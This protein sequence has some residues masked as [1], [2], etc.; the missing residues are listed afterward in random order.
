MKYRTVLL[1][2]A[3]GAGKGT[4]GKILGA[5]PGIFHFA[6]GDAFRNL[7][8][9][10]P[11]GRIFIDYSSRGELVPDEPTINLWRKNIQS[12]VVQGRFQPDQDTLVLDGIP[13]NPEQ[14]A[15]LR[16]TIDV[17]A[18]FNLTCSDMDKMV[19]RL[20]RRALREN[21][22]D[23]ANL[24]TIKRRLQTYERETRPVLDYYGPEFVH[25]IDS[26]QKPVAVLMDILKVICKL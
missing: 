24:E 5:V 11:L 9:D 13:R 21:R 15:M 6:C 17:K 23:D 14:A 10:D 2:G 20:Q 12:S 3:P 22:L 18:I 7:R 19:E 25:V 1:F 8:I 16:D 4:Q 26:T